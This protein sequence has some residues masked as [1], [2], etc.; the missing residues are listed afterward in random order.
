MTLILLTGK[1]K[2][3]K[4]LDG[5]TSDSEQDHIVA[6]DQLSDKLPMDDEVI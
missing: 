6:Q 4:R 5:D 2:L 1:K 3:R